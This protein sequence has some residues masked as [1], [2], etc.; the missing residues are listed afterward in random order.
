M[1]FF[2]FK[3]ALGHA[4]YLH[5]LLWWYTFVFSALSFG[6]HSSRLDKTNEKVYEDPIFFTSLFEALISFSL[7]LMS[8][9][10]PKDIPFAN[11][12]YIRAPG[13]LV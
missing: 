5:K 9:L 13:Q 1:M 11:R 3:R 6:Y 8:V 2:E 10:Y 7:G 12:T 4:W